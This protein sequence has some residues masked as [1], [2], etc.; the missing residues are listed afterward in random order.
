MVAPQQQQQNRNVSLVCSHPDVQSQR[1][2]TVISEF[3]KHTLS[4]NSAFQHTVYKKA[5]AQTPALATENI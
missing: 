3:G 4:E 2:S 5:W 1:V